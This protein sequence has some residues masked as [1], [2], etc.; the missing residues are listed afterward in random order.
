MV[1]EF[2]TLYRLGWRGPLFLVDDNFIGNK[3]EAMELLP[4]L[5]EWQK[6]H[7]YPFSLST[8]ASV[9]LAHLDEL[10]DA[11]GRVRFRHRVPRASRRPIPRR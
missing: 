8:E 9:N 10:M 1:T 2:E 5:A 6:A 3:R 7:G 4:V 11:D